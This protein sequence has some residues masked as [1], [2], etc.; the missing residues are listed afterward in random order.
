MYDFSFSRLETD[1]RSDMVGSLFACAFFQGCIRKGRFV[2]ERFVEFDD[3]I[4][5]E[6]IGNAA[7]ILGCIADDLVFFRD[8]LYV[9]SLIECVHYDVR[10]FVFGKSEAEHGGT[11]GRGQFGLHVVLGQIDFVI[12]RFGDF[13][14]MREPA[15]AFILVELRSADNRHDGKLAVVVD[16]GA[17]LV[18]LLE[19]A[20]F[21]GR[22]NVCPSVAHL[23]GLR[24]PEVHPPGTCN[25]RIG[26]TSRQFKSRL[27]PHQ[28]IHILHRVES[29]ICRNG[30]PS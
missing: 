7:A 3:E 15:G 4:V 1:Y 2:S 5:L 22:I 28:R 17:R 16:P 23:S 30:R 24:R 8:H 6:V 18:G 12:I 29:R 21:V 19:T 14:F 26:I 13:A 10:M 27:R 9:R 11:V 20:Y 25:G